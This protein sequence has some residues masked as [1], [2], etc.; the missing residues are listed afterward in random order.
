[1]EKNKSLKEKKPDTKKP[2]L[3]RNYWKIGIIVLA[4]ALAGS[5]SSAWFGYFDQF[6]NY[7]TREGLSA[8]EA[9]GKAVAFINENFLQG[10]TTASLLE[11]TEDKDSGLYKIKIKIGE[12]EY[13][14][15]VS[16][17]GKLLFPEVVDLN[18]TSEVAGETT[19]EEA[20][21]EVPKKE[22]S[23]AK[24]F[25][26]AFCPFGNQAEDLMYPVQKL[27]GDK[28]KIEPHY[29]IYSDYQGGG[30][31]WC[32]DEEN[33]YCSMHGVQELNQG[34]RELCV[35]KYQKD[36]FWD[37]VEDVNKDCTAQDVD[38]CWEKVAKALGIDVS[39]IK[40]CQKDEALDLLANEVVLNEKYNVE[41]SP[42][43]VIN[44]VKYEG[45]RS[46]EGYKQ[47][48]CSG[49]ENPPKECNETLEGAD[50]STSG[51][52]E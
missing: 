14:S 23:E 22:V 51:S 42:D 11:T 32:L 52:C 25:T 47:G 4:I 50:S 5:I 15:Y 8:D 35:F 36:K 28:A 33:K 19:Q 49:F 29:V 24:L 45:E 17:N 41:G 34:V 38:T 9:S 31:E 18:K 27:L 26:M 40:T 30:S 44:D 21:Q 46:A 39:K 43:L 7:L 48:I 13:D 12:Q 37:F 3:K 10:E 16:K 1:M 20:S 6:K 2:K